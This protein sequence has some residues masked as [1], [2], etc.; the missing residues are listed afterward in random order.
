MKSMTGF[1]YGEY[2]DERVQL[3]LEIKSYNNRYLDVVVNVPSAI[4]PVEQRI[5]DFVALNAIRGRIEV[6]LKVR[7]LREDAE[8]H[9][10]RGA[11]QG[12]L[13]ALRELAALSGAKSEISLP[14]LLQLDGILT[15]DRRRDTEEYWRLIEPLLRTTF[16]EFDSSRS[17]EGE[18]TRADIDSQLSRIA[19]QVDTIE[20]LAPTLEEQI[21]SSLRA[22]FEE[23]MGDKVD[24]NRLYTEAAVLLVRYSINEEIVRMKTHINAFRQT[25]TDGE[26][27]KGVGKKLDFICQELN[28][29]INT[30]GSKS[31][32]V[33]INQCGIEIK[34]ALEN[35]REQLR[36][37][38]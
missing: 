37:V 34:D 17:R 9:L 6:Y 7:D 19:A 21:K 23:V 27:G 25:L 5:R 31:T 12:Y 30:T 14:L 3:S 8:V 26:Q 29:E 1:G 22:R 33:E 28:R 13:S 11:V 32:I 18:S 2:Q 4:G 24:E 15:V 10:D 35:I 36:N 20:R 38:E 16:G